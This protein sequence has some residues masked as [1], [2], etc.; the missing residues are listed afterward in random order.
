MAEL[1]VYGIVLGAIIALGA[2]GLS[3][4]YGILRFANFS[5]G[6]IMTLGAYLCLFF[7]IGPLNWLKIPEFNLGALSF[8]PRMLCALVLSMISVSFSVVLI[9]RIIFR[10]LRRKK[11][12]ST[13][14]AIS[15]FGVSFILQMIIFIL[16]GADSL[17]YKPGILRPA[18]VL[19][20]DIKIRPDQ[21]FILVIV[22]ILCF[23]FHLFLSFSKLGKAMRACADN[24]V[25]ARISGIDPERVATWTWV[26]GGAMAGLS[27]VLYGIDVQLSPTMGFGFILPL[28]SATI[29]GGIGNVY[30]AMIGAFIIGIVE[31]ISTAFLLPAYKPAVAFLILIFLLLFRPKGLFGGKS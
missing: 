23:L 3:M 19:P 4:V 7:F 13:T 17:F 28:F 9:D 8:G 12:S 2:I 18:L 16:F 25:L 11:S 14:L 21:I 6:D 27:G 1:F 22:F 31:Q 26:I 20:F 29:L 30:G 10:P 15:S 24:P 5:H